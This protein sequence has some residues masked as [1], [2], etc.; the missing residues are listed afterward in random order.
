M[1]EVEVSHLRTARHN[2]S[3]GEVES[4]LLARKVNRLERTGKFLHAGLDDGQVLVAHLGMS[5]RFQIDGNQ[6]AHT[7][8]RCLL[9]SGSEIRFVDPRT[10][11]FVA[12]YESAELSE[13]SIGRL[14]PDAWESP[15]T[16]EELGQALQ[17]RTAPVKALLLDQSLIAG[18][19]NIYA[20]EALYVARIHPLREG[21][22]LEIAELDELL[23]AIRVV[24]SAALTHG[25][26]SL[27]DLAYLLPDGEA[28]EN[29]GHLQ[30]YGRKDLPCSRCGTP[31]TRVTVRSRSTHFCPSCQAER[32]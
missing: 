29:L 21:R 24:L 32:Q 16:S 11:G 28:G 17:N 20:D 1:S 22:S 31:I 8:F 15:P 18:L 13:S 7:H 19:G 6:A 25:G 30:A 12:V 27:D 10:F 23:G 9:E 2:S 3:P 26:T 14:G 4:R 5:G